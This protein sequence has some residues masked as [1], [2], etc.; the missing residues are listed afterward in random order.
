M[1]YNILKYQN[2]IGD[3]NWLTDDI[4]VILLVN[5]YV[6][7]IDNHEYLDDVLQYEITGNGY[8]SGGSQLT[9]KVVTRDNVNDRI[10]FSADS[11][12]WSSATI[13]TYGCILYKRTSTLGNS[14]L[15][16]YINFGNVRISN[17]TPFR[18]NWSQQEGIFYLE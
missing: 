16:N 13:S 10:I 7:D 9:N 8:T 15:V 1:I 4:R 2:A 17:N 6:V 12:I 3:F 5:N 18:I 14:Y 11:V